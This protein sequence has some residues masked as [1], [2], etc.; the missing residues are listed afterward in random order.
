MV[1]VI[2]S[3]LQARNI[4]VLLFLKYEETTFFTIFVYSEFRSPQ[5]IKNHL[6]RTTHLIDLLLCS[7]CR[8]APVMP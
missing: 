3:I 8:C 1:R 6:R 4:L 5:H 7:N 2:P